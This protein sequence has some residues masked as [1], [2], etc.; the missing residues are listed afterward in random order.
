MPTIKCGE[1]LHYGEIPCP[2]EWLFISDVEFDKFSGSVDAE[3]IY[4]AMKILIKCSSCGTMWFFGDGFAGAQWEPKIWNVGW[5]DTVN[6]GETVTGIEEGSTPVRFSEVSG[7]NT[8]SEIRVNVQ[9]DKIVTA[10]VTYEKQAASIDGIDTTDEP[11][12]IELDNVSNEGEDDEYYYTVIL[13]HDVVESEPYYSIGKTDKFLSSDPTVYTIIHIDGEPFYRAKFEWYYP[14]GDFHFKHESKWSDERNNW[15][16]W[17]FIKIKDNNPASNPGQWS[18]KIFVDVD[19]GKGWEHQT[20][21]YFT[22]SSANN[23]SDDLPSQP[24]IDTERPTCEISG[25]NS[26]YTVGIMF[27]ILQKVGI[28]RH[29]LNCILL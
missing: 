22:I 27:L 4:K 6:S 12:P 24:Q 13:S 21:K 1:I 19:N 26:T 10:S 5:G 23:D 14:N 17:A 16:F 8:P 20:T 3:E 7:W 2:D 29:C 11:E 15:A 25:I 9:A 28:M 18:V